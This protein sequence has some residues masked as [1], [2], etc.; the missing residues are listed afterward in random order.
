ML[1]GVGA[2]AGGIATIMLVGTPIGWGVIL[3]VGAATA[4]TSWAASEYAGSIYKSQFSDVDVVNSL[5]ITSI[6]N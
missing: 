5:G 4:A 1:A 3:L 6:C 2:I